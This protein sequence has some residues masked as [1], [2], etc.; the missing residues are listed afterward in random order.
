MSTLTSPQPSGWAEKLQACG[1]LLL[2]LCVLFVY[3]FAMLVHTQAAPIE[4]SVAAKTVYDAQPVIMVVGLVITGALVVGGILIAV[5]LFRRRKVAWG[6]LYVFSALAAGAAGHGLLLGLI[7]G[8]D[9]HK[10]PVVYSVQ[11][12][13]SI[14][15]AVVFTVISALGVWALQ[16]RRIVDNQWAEAESRIHTCLK[17]ITIGDFFGTLPGVLLA[18]V[19]VAGLAGIVTGAW[20]L[21]RMD[22]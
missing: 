4:E 11:A 14:I 15:S 9:I 21:G 6:G 10:I 17:G 13:V 1:S 18:G 3:G 7:N 22:H 19:L 5:G 20:G 12:N 2:V 16:H 8:A